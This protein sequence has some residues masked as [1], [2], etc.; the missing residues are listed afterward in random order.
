MALSGNT[1]HWVVCTRQISAM[2][3]VSIVQIRKG[4]CTR[5][6][7]EHT[8]NSLIHCQL[9]PSLF[10]FW[11]LSTVEYIWASSSSVLG[12]SPFLPFSS[13]V[14]WRTCHNS[15]PAGVGVLWDTLTTG[16]EKSHAVDV[17]RK[18]H[19]WGDQYY[20]ELGTWNIHVPIMYYSWWDTYIVTSTLHSKH[21]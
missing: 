14:S 8:K 10:C 1:P 3:I 16:K 9:T 13:S 6:L 4:W 18:I 20:P 12:S 15:L 21:M 11:F 7:R 17:G 5:S 2:I 19:H